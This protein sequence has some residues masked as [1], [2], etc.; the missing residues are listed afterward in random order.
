MKFVIEVCVSFS[1][2][3]KAIVAQASIALL[4]TQSNVTSIVP[5]PVIPLELGSHPKPT[6]IAD[7]LVDT[8]PIDKR[9]FDGAGARQVAGRL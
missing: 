3:I 4:R 2:R 6:Q 5:Y 7:A 1:D 8:V 9:R